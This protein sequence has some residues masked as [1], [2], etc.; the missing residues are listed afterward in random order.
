MEANST[1][2]SS[3]RRRFRPRDQSS[4]LQEELMIIANPVNNTNEDSLLEGGIS[5]KANEDTIDDSYSSVSSHFEDEPE[6]ESMTAKGIQNL[7]S[8]LLELKDE[9]AEDFKMSICS[10][11]SVFLGIFGQMRGLE[12]ELMQLKS[13]ASTQ[14]RVIQEL[15]RTVP[16]TVLSEEIMETVFEESCDDRPDSS[17]LEAHTDDVLEILDLLIS[18]NRLDEAL[19]VLEMEDRALESMRF[20]ESFSV[21]EMKAYDSAIAQKRALLADHL[22]QLAKNPRVSA[23]ELQ[24]ALIGLCK[25][26]NA[27]LA[28]H[29]LLDYYSARIAKR[30]QDFN[31][32]IAFQNGLT[33][34]EVAKYVFSMISQ[35]ARC[36]LGL[37]GEGTIYAP[38]L[39][40]WS[41]AKTEVFAAIL[42][43]YVESTSEI[44]GGLSAVVDAFQ[45]ALSYCSLL[46]DQK[47]FLRSSLMNHISPCIEQILH[48]Q[49]DHYKKVI[50]IFTSTDTWIIGRYLV[51]G[52]LSKATP[53]LDVHEKPEYCLL[54]NSGRKFLTLFQDILDD[55][56]PL[57]ALQLEVVLLKELKELFEEY[58]TIL[59]AALTSDESPI[60]LT[61]SRIHPADSLI[62]GVSVIANL[63]TIMELFSNV[64]RSVFGNIDH[65]K[66][67]IDSYL[68]FNQETH[69]RFKAQFIQ[70]FIQKLFSC[71][72]DKIHLTESCISLQSDSDGW[73]LGPSMPYQAFYLELRKLKKFA[74]GSY[75]EVNWLED[76][77]RELIE[78]I[79][80][81]ISNEGGSFSATE[82]LFEEQNCSRLMQ[83]ILDIQ[84]LEEI[85]RNGGSISDNMINT[86]T[87]ILAQIESSLPS[88]QFSLDRY[89][90]GRRLAKDAAILAIQKLEEFDE[91]ES[92]TL[93]IADNFKY[94][95]KESESTNASDMCE[96]DQDNETHSKHSSESP[97][98][99][100]PV[101]DTPAEGDTSDECCFVDCFEAMKESSST[102]VSGDETNF[103]KATI[104]SLHEMLLAENFVE[105]PPED[106][107]SNSCENTTQDGQNLSSF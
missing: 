74:E 40:Q 92:T 63:S 98:K 101:S 59:E 30:M 55:C 77:L 36:F 18:E 2:T 87:N 72:S 27:H 99:D 6:L 89:A 84:F 78:E 62:Q 104:N 39:V 105:E 82:A 46:E 69:A 5:N 58:I 9:S 61:G 71:E 7:C 83:F 14:K 86:S 57:V 44:S 11:Y 52:V 45:C 24:Q 50:C 3:R 67:E 107:I 12:S 37:H 15:A 25:L 96:D 93:E 32:S 34:R 4:N 33:T 56:S 68:Q 51:S 103:E 17:N 43:K 94:D 13:Q 70:K 31:S 95:T 22:T 73:N 8:E 80:V 20:R 106:P 35:A 47:L 65:L 85:A 75:I 81:W 38:E 1:S 66:F 88:A 54:T 97:K 91:K 102:E 60:E 29:L 49:V 90:T 42:T 41:E 76:L 64:I 10:N 26:G 28:L 79:F 53:R 19:S 23:P 21:E 48:R 16:L 100:L